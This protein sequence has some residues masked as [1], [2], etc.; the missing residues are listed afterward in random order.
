MKIIPKAV[1]LVRTESVSATKPQ[2][3]PYHPSTKPAAEQAPRADQVQISDAG[4]AMAERVEAGASP[5][6]EE[7]VS[8]IRTRLLEG[9]YNQLDVVDEV[10]RRIL[11]SG[12]L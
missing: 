10:A 11:D 2:G 9:A 12:D 3:S 5:L 8:Q 6:S 4:R 1:E 7:R